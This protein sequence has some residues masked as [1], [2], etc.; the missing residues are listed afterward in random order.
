MVFNEFVV[1]SDKI[2]GPF[3]FVYEYSHTKPPRFNK[4]RIQD[5]PHYVEQ[6]IGLLFKVY[7]EFSERYHIFELPRSHA[8]SESMKPIEFAIHA[9][10]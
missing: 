3:N 4:H 1:I 6:T 10:V 2:S 7:Y 5:I 9:I 8:T